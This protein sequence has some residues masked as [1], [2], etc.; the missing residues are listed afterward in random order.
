M[1]AGSEQPA[2]TQAA[3]VAG[4]LASLP[5][6]LLLQHLYYGSTA[7]PAGCC[8]CW[9]C[10]RRRPTAVAAAAAARR[11]GAPCFDAARGTGR[12]ARLGEAP[13]AWAWAAREARRATRADD[14]ARSRAGA[15]ARPGPARLQG[16]GRGRGAAARSRPTDSSRPADCRRAAARLAR[17]EER[18][19]GA[20]GPLARPDEVKDIRGAAARRRR[21]C[22]VRWGQVSDLGSRARPRAAI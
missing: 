19:R 18:A 21:L 9:C 10:C 15:A 14:P 3:G 17:G 6:F 11:A 22:A 2:A 8:C 13:S 12:R 1:A 5:A 16:R 7:P 20:C 4:A